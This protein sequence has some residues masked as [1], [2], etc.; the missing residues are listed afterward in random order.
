MKLFLFYIAKIRLHFARKK[1]VK[2]KQ[3]MDDIIHKTYAAKV[4]IDKSYKSFLE[5]AKREEECAINLRRIRKMHTERPILRVNVKADKYSL[6]DKAEKTLTKL[7]V[8][9]A[10]VRHR[11]GDW[12]V[13]KSDCWRQNNDSVVKKNG[14]IIS[15]YPGVGNN[16]FYVETD[17]TGGK[18]TVRLDGEAA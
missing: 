7:D 16:Y 1:A 14:K 5:S 9:T 15:L 18:T 11:H 6:S 13:V 17:L 12:G 8:E 10:L 3:K 4:E 2:S